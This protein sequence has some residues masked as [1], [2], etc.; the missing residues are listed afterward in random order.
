MI[1]EKV[2]EVRRLSREEKWALIDELWD[3]LIPSPDKAVT[4]EIVALLDRRMEE[5]ERDASTGSP[6]SE[7]KA[8]LRAARRSEA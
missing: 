7:V 2:P 8:R 1:I 3:E 6:W 5:Y 4:A